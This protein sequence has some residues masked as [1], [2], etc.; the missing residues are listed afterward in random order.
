MIWREPLCLVLVRHQRLVYA[1]TFCT[2]FGLFN[3]G[4]LTTINDCLYPRMGA[5]RQLFF[6]FLYGFGFYTR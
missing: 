4:A 2:P 3:G 1:I 6:S 5:Y